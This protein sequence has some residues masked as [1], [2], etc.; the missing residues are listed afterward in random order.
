MAKDYYLYRKNRRTKSSNVLLVNSLT[1]DGD[2]IVFY[3]GRMRPG[4]NSHK[5]GRN[6]Y[7]VSSKDYEYT[8]V[9]NSCE[10]DLPI[11]ELREKKERID[12]YIRKVNVS[13]DP[14]I[15]D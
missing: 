11:F 13:S 12:D 6:K 15:S 4:R 1:D 2:I 9:G 3:R 7:D 8:P 5:C 10:H 14:I